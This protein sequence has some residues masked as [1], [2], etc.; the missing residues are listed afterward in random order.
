MES[1]LKPC[2]F[3]FSPAEKDKHGAV[4]CTNTDCPQLYPSDAPDVARWNSRPIED[5][6]RTENEKLRARCEA[7]HN[8]LEANKKMVSFFAGITV[9]L[10]NALDA[11]G[12]EAQGLDHLIPKQKDLFDELGTAMRALEAFNDRTK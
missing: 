11:A 9:S 4:Y 2:P 10:G 7:Y 12:L 8:A 3:C 5:A 6:L 1:E